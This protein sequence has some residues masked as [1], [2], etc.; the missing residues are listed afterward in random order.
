[1]G[2]AT[3]SPSEYSVDTAEKDT[4]SGEYTCEATIGSET[5]VSDP[6]TVTV[7]GNL[8]TFLYF[9]WLQD[10]T[11]LDTVLGTLYIFLYFN[12]LQDRTHLDRIQAVLLL[13]LDKINATTNIPIFLPLTIVIRANI[14][15]SG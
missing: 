2:P 13:Y 6:A 14:Q 10:S 4:H 11:H 15:I 8:Y 12:R 9:N 7:L 3:L 1:M 5:L